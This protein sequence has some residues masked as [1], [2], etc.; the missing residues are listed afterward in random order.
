MDA[1]IHGAQLRSTLFRD[2]TT[3]GLTNPGNNADNSWDKRA[4]KLGKTELPPDKQ[5]LLTNSLRTS[6]SPT[7]SNDSWI[8]L[9]KGELD[10]VC[11]SDDEDDDDDEEEEENGVFSVKRSSGI[12]VRS[13][14]KGVVK[15]IEVP[16][17]SS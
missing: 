6:T 15:S 9:C 7:A 1:P 11:K 13:F 2:A 3:F 17:G 12:L 5:T 8:S 14:P 4:S 16:S 10:N